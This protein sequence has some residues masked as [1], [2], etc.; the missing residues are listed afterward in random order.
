MLIAA[1]DLTVLQMLSGGVEGRDVDHRRSPKESVAFAP[2]AAGS[3]KLPLVIAFHG[4]GDSMQNFAEDTG[5]HTVWSEA[6][7]V[8]I[9]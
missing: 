3:A 9:R 2:A 8:Y 4:R 1:A 7:V 5:I 6:I